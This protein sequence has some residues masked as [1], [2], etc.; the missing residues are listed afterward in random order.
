MLD[1][2]KDDAFYSTNTVN[3]TLSNIRSYNVSLNYYQA[4]AEY[5]SKKYSNTVE[6]SA[7]VVLVSY[8]L[9]MAYRIHYK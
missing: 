6:Y 3:C 1:F 2:V 5:L 7:L 9:Y 4:K 8:N